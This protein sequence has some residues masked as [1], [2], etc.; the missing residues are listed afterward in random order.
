MKEKRLGDL[1][2]LIMALDTSDLEE[3]RRLADAVRPCVDIVKVGLQLF[4]TAGIDAVEVLRSDGFEIFLD[5]KMMDIP[6]TVSTAC[7]ALCEHEPLML[8]LH[9]LGGQEMMR[10]ATQAVRDHCEA[11]GISRP[12]LIG[13][14]VLTSLD[15]LALKKIGVHESIEEQ[16]VRLAKLARDSGMDGLVS[17]PLETLLVRREVGPGM[18]LI[19]PGVRLTGTGMDDQKRVATPY[20]AMRS[21]ADFLVVGRPLYRAKDP[22][23]VAK[24]MLED[25]RRAQDPGAGGGDD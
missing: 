10:A 17:S 24:Q 6:N 1:S 13:V 2:P 20:D 16:V 9:T 14:T 15:L 8:T 11:G 7:L 12:L 19:T 23:A 3:A 4:S 22:L 5:I 25:A 21:G 18:I